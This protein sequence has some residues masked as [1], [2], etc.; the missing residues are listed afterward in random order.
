MSVKVVNAEKAAF[1]VQNCL[2][3]I[4]VFAQS[5]VRTSIGKLELQEILD[6]RA[7]INEKVIADL[8]DEIEYWGFTVNRCEISSIEAK[9]ARVK[10]SL[11]DQINAE[12]LSKE[13]H[14]QADSY[15][16]STKN[17]TDAEY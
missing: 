10:S 15:Y 8:K 9:N 1:N 13:K 3:A 4:R 11:N 14:I 16:L 7:V 5:S 12:Q 17:K 2:S 6:N